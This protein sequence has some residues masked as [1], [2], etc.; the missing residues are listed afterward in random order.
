MDAQ[1]DDYYYDQSFRE[2]MDIEE[3]LS[4]DDIIDSD[5]LNIDLIQKVCQNCGCS[6]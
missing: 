6:L 4:L 5:N 2:L 3:R 1:P